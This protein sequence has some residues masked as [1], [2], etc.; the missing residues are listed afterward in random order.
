MLF[1]VLIP[2]TSQYGNKIWTRFSGN[3]DSNGG[4]NGVAVDS[5]GNIYVTGF[6]NAGLDGQ[7]NS[8]DIESTTD[9]VLMKYSTT[10]TKL[11][12]RLTGTASNDVGNGIAIDSSGNI[13]V[14]GYVSDILDFQPFA[15]GSDIV[16]IKYDSSGNKMWTRLAG[17]TG[18]DY[19]NAVAVDSTGNIF[20]TGYVSNALDGQIF[21]GSYDIVLMKY[22][23]T[24]HRQ[25]TRLRG[26]NGIDLGYGVATDTIGNVFVTGHV[27]ASL[28]GQA[29]T[30][31]L[32]DIVVIKYNTTGHRLWTK[33]T[34]TADD[35]YS[36]GLAVDTSGFI[37]LVGTISVSNK[38]AI[39]GINA[40]G[41]N[42]IVLM[43]YNSTTGTKVWTRLAGSS[44]NDHGL[45]VTVDSSKNVL[46]S[47]FV[48]AAV[49]SQ[50]YGGGLFDMV[51]VKYNSSGHKI[52][53]RLAGS[54]STDWGFAVTTDASGNVFVT[55]SVSGDFDNQK[56]AGRTDLVL[57]KYSG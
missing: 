21:R 12:T 23:T 39:D 28:D 48:N 54:A 3:P 18:Y 47:G 16:L 44:G 2:C 40:I 8:G 1:A 26:T 27:S 32:F 10:G 52:W 9:I 37:Y 41:D 33:L 20:V 22:N 35:D 4:G 30:G 55:G 45:G 34:G 7:S 38:D 15:G 19:G 46:V 42:E 51:V 56:K 6:I 49:D 25:W 17:S 13:Y 5:S 36:L 43:K 14:T 11:W 57:I 24:G 31:G 53:T 29:F 50:A